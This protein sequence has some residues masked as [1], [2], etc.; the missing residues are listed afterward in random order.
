MRRVRQI[1]DGDV[2][3]AERDG[4]A[5]S[6]HEVGG[7]GHAGGVVGGGGGEDGGRGGVG[8]GG[9]VEQ[10]DHAAAEGIAG[11]H[12]G[13]GIVVVVV[14]LV[15][16]GLGETAPIPAGIH[17]FDVAGEV[18]VLHRIADGQLRVGDHQPIATGPGVTA[19]R[20]QHEGCRGAAL[21]RVAGGVVGPQLFDEL[22]QVGL[23]DV[24]GKRVLNVPVALE[25]N[26]AGDLEALRRPLRVF[27]GE[28][29]EHVG[30][31]E[32][33]V[34]RPVSGGL[35]TDSRLRIHRGRVSG[36]AGISHPLVAHVNPRRVA[37]RV[38]PVRGA[39]HVV[40][41]QE[42]IVILFAGIPDKGRW[43]AA[44][45]PAA[46]AFSV[47]GI[48]RAV[49]GDARTAGR[50]DVPEQTAVALGRLDEQHRFVMIPAHDVAEAEFR[51]ERR[52]RGTL[53]CGQ[54]SLAGG[55]DHAAVHHIVAD[56][57]VATC[58]EQVR[59][60]VLPFGYGFERP[61]G[62]AG[63]ETHADHIGLAGHDV[64]LDWLVGRSGRAVRLGQRIG[65]FRLAIGIVRVGE[66]GFDLIPIPHPVAIAVGQQRIGMIDIHFLSVA[67]SIAIGVGQQRIGMVDLDLIS[68]AESVAIGICQQRTGMVNIDFIPVTE[69]V[70]V[71][72]GVLGV[73]PELVFL[74]V[75]QTVAVRIVLSARV[76]GCE[77][78]RVAEILV[79]PRVGDAVA[80][81]VG[82]H[83]AELHPGGRSAG[84]HTVE[85]RIHPP[86]VGVGDRRV[87]S[88][89]S[90][91]EAGGD[92]LG[93]C[94]RVGAEPD[95]HPH[96]GAGGRDQVGPAHGHVATRNGRPI[97][98]RGVHRQGEAD[99]EGSVIAGVGGDRRRAGSDVVV[100]PA[101]IGIG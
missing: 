6:Q 36:F 24:G 45:R 72:I 80:V 25:P 100:C 95:V 32:D 76:V 58:L 62:S 15:S 74:Q 69:P 4:F 51:A 66:A 37:R 73:G 71:G 97:V 61:R 59:E 49:V 42:E 22:D 39:T 87:D 20:G 68:V 63:N 91:I 82:N 40:F 5:E 101:G 65:D 77:S 9:G 11:Q 12:V 30:H 28:V 52:C 96:V 38:H 57:P 86:V 85:V 14:T 70:A 44:C 92:D 81:G 64:N 79:H 84:R 35:R 46:W 90:R 75:G 19:A 21:A 99:M 47:T 13:F 43:T 93:Q 23:I 56:R 83:E 33:R 41:G 78:R 98:G 88:C 1:L 3:R 18:R 50:Q 60:L 29:V 17:G 8:A 27:G 34:N 16:R 94:G 53:A 55:G 31:V 89:G 7:D 54:R 10:V 2:A 67:E 48:D 26:V